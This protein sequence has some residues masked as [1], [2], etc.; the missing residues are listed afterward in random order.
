M[1]ATN[2]ATYSLVR[3]PAIVFDTAKTAPYTAANL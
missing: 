3:Q 1:T 2:S